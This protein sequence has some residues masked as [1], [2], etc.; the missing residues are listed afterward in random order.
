M[1]FVAVRLH[2]ILRCPAVAVAVGM[3][4]DLDKKRQSLWLVASDQVIQVGVSINV[5]G[6]PPSSLV[7][8]HFR[9]ELS[10]LSNFG[11]FISWKIPI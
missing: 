7:T 11:W 3:R 9:L 8:N 6:L 2:W 4:Q 10:N 5:M 1:D